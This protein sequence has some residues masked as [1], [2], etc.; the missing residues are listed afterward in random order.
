[1]GTG[2]S[3]A[4]EAISEAGFDLEDSPYPEFIRRY[5]AG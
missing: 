1:D 3:G 4:L 5:F 2:A